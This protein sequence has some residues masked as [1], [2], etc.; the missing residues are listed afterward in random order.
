MKE[1]EIKLYW[2]KEPNFVIIS[3]DGIKS[4]KSNRSF[5]TFK[6]GDYSLK[7]NIKNNS[8]DNKINQQQILQT[9]S[10]FRKHIIDRKNKKKLL[11]DKVMKYNTVN[12]NNQLNEKKNIIKDEKDNIGLISNQNI[13]KINYE[14]ENCEDTNINIR[15]NNK[16]FSSIII[17][18]ENKLSENDNKIENEIEEN[19]ASSINKKSIRTQVNKK[20]RQ[21][22]IQQSD[23]AEISKINS[24]SDN[25]TDFDNKLKIST[26]FKKDNTKSIKGDI[27]EKEEFENELIDNDKDIITEMNNNKNE[28]KEEKILVLQ[29]EMKKNNFIDDE[30]DKNIEIKDEENIIKENN[31]DKDNNI[32]KIDEIMNNNIQKNEGSL[33]SENTSERKNFIPFIHSTIIKKNIVNQIRERKQNIKNA[34]IRQISINKN[35][36]RNKVSNSNIK[37]SIDES[38]KTSFISMQFIQKNCFICEKKH[39]VV[40]LFCANCKIHFLC[41]KCLKNYYEEFIENN[42]NI[43][44]LK[45]PFTKCD[46]KMNY[47]I[48]KYIISENHQK[49][50]ESTKTENINPNE[51]LLNNTNNNNLKK[52][53]EK[54]VIDINTNKNF[55]LFKKTKDIICPKCL[56]PNLFSKTGNHFL[57]CLNCCYKMCKHCLKEYNEKHMDI[58]HEGYCKVYFRRDEDISEKQSCILVYLLQLIFVIAMYLFTFC[59]SYFFSYKIFKYL[60]N[61]E[62]KGNNINYYIKKFFIII[63]SIIFFIISFP[64]IIVFYPYFPVFIALCDY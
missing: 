49:I 54:H 52:Y 38:S 2:E 58:N 10:D 32:I 59:G 42:N 6:E 39:Y 57:K 19:F 53:T 48:I 50:Y 44:E 27:N 40:K 28:E 46:E 45:C 26:R 21:K 20:D 33:I 15:N 47:D 51:E 41:R 22:S 60:L 1:K 23:K 43:K 37:S 17:A 5:L 7:I 30:N 63:F 3:K 11:E 14:N 16:E 64:I 24:E 31:K 9:L 12:I 62:K 18:D 61:L 36:L 35:N 55:F 34:N 8:L 29:N 56:N 4:S 13:I 25:V